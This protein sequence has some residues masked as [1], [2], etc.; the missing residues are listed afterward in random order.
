MDP[1]L[2]TNNA[3]SA[4]TADVGDAVASDPA[5]PSEQPPDP[6]PKGDTG[7]A[8]AVVTHSKAVTQPAPDSWI[9]KLIGRKSKSRGQC[10]VCGAFH[11][12]HTVNGLLVVWAAWRQST[13]RRDR[14]T[15]LYFGASATP[16]R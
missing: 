15:A 14:P 4:A 2:A 3:A 16:A 8:S 5:A 1:G 13:M 10:S 7:A 6:L 9:P 11:A 12:L